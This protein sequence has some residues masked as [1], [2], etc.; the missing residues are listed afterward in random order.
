MLTRAL[1]LAAAVALAAPAFAQDQT[2]PPQ[3]DLSRVQEQIRS[4]ADATQNQL[5]GAQQQ[6]NRTQDRVQDRV[7]GRQDRIQ[8]RV[9]G[10]QDGAVPNRPGNRQDM[11]P[12]DRPLTRDGQDRRMQPRDGQPGADAPMMNVRGNASA[13]PSDALVRWVRQDNQAE[14]ALAEYAKQKSQNPAVKDFAEKMIQAH[15]QFGQKLEA[16]GGGPSAPA[17]DLPSRRTSAFRGGTPDPAADAAATDAAAIE[18][19]VADDVLRQDALTSEEAAVD[20]IVDE[21]TDAADT[22]LADTP[23]DPA[24]NPNGLQ[25]RTAMRPVQGNRGGS[26][27]DLLAFRE[28]LTER[29]GKTLKQNFDKL[30][31]ADFDKA[32]ASQQ[33]GAHVAM[34]ETLAMAAEQVDGPAADV[35]KAGRVDT[36]QHLTMAIGLLND[37]TNNPAAGNAN[38][39]GANNRGANNRAANN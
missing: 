12:G 35:F 31:P 10:V 32:Y 24:Q 37:V 21:V 18:D 33:I 14:I 25:E 19:Q 11:R 23:Q 8:G 3:D 15:T 38:N 39:R 22:A 28:Q 27:A 20:Q 4:G 16:L 13:V 2:P 36:Q 1:S 5:D 6:I 34:L 29:H 17:A 26:T 7:E 30:S 9:D